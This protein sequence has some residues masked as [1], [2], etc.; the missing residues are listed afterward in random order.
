VVLTRAQKSE[1]TPMV[2]SR[3]IQRL[4]QL[5]RGLGSI[6]KLAL[7]PQY[8]AIAAAMAEPGAPTPERPPYPKPPVAARPRELSVTDVERWVRDPY[9]IYAKKILRLRPLDPLDA[10]IGFLERGSAFH[11]VLERFIRRHAEV[12]ADAAGKIVTIVDEVLAEMALPRA[13]TAIWR[14]RFIRAAQWFV[15]LEA[16]RRPAIAESYLEVRGVLEFST[17]EGSFKLHGIAD[18]IDRLRS[19]GAVIIDYKTGTPPSGS[20]VKVLLSPQLP[21]EGAILQAGG[22]VGVP[23]LTPEGLAYIQISG[24][25]EAGKLKDVTDDAAAQSLAALDR[26][27]GRAALFDLADTGYESH[28]A[29]VHLD[30]EGDFDHLARVREWSMSGWSGE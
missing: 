9:S 7:D 14:P 19:G 6:D 20:Q 17:G 4:Q 10:D 28:V 22:F 21:L 13:V 12:P 16:Q 5:T 18:R 30:S 1:G 23:A 25:A 2:A 15:N 29:P 8:R 11:A 26:L 3:W 27:K 24:A